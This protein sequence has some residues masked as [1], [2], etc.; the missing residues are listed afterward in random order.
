MKSIRDALEKTPDAFRVQR[1]LGE[2]EFGT[3]YFVYSLTW[4]RFFAIKTLK[5]KYDENSDV[6]EWFRREANIWTEL[7]KHPYFI[8]VYWVDEIAGRLCIV[9]A[10]LPENDA[11]LLS[12]ADHLAE[13]PP[14]ISQT[15]QWAIEFCYGMSYAYSKGVRCHRDIKAQKHLNWPR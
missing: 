5:E 8:H 3:V 2:G 14:N 13:S 4:G 1:V 15:L 11:G 7:G 12:L 6:R 9:M 10:Y